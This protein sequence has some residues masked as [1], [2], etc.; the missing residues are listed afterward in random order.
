MASLVRLTVQLQQLALRL[1]GLLLA[2]GLAIYLIAW[3]LDPPPQWLNAFF[4]SVLLLSLVSHGALHARKRAH[5]ST[6]QVD[7]GFFSSLTVAIYALILHLPGSLGGPFY[8]LVYVVM[9]ASAAYSRPTSAVATVL[10]AGMLEVG[11]SA[12]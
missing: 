7:L 2:G 11:L 3:A 5:E 10:F 8:P 6:Q 1:S 4:A 12:E 9:M